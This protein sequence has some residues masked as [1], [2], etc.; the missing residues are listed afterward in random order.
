MTQTPLQCPQCGGRAERDLRQMRRTTGWVLIGLSL[1][2]LVALALVP[3]RAPLVS[4]LVC[5][6]L[7]L[8]GVVALR[9]APNARY[10]VDCKVRMVERRVSPK[11]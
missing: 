4:L 9:G 5:V 3:W 2:V 8:L 11:E 7:A 1:A 6:V 10:C